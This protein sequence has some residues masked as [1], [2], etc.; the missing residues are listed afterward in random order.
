MAETRTSNIIT[1]DQFEKM[2]QSP[3]MGSTSASSALKY[4]QSRGYTVQGYAGASPKQAVSIN[5]QNVKQQSQGGTDTKWGQTFGDIVQS[6]AP[7]QVGLGFAEKIANITTKPLGKA[8]EAISPEGSFGERFGQNLQTAGSDLLGEAETQREENLRKIGGTTAVVGATLGGGALARGAASK[9][10]GAVIPKLA[11]VAGFAGESVGATAGY[12]ASQGKEIT[13]QDLKT[14]LLIDAAIQGVFKIPAASKL[15]MKAIK[16]LSKSDEAVEAGVKKA[17]RGI[18]KAGLDLPEQNLLKEIPTE[19]KDFTQKA[20]DQA[21]KRSER[22]VEFGEGG[23]AAKTN[24][25]MD[26]VGDDI[27]LIKNKIGSELSKT[28]KIIGSEAKKLKG[29]AFPD[30]RSAFTE[31]K[32]SLDDLNIQLNKKGE[33]TND[34]FKGSDIDGL[35]D[36][37][38]LI[39]ELWGYLKESTESAMTENARDVLSKVRNIGNKLFKGKGEITAAKNPINKVRA[40]LRKSLEELPGAYGEA[41]RKYSDLLEIEDGL[42]RSVG[43]EGEKASQFVRRLFG[44]A[45]GQAKSIVEMIEDAASKYNIKSGENITGKT[46]IAEFLDRASGVTPPQGLQGQMSEAGENILRKGV[47]RGASEAVIDAVAKKLFNTPEKLDAIQAFLDATDNPQAVQE[48]TAV[49]DELLKLVEEGTT[50][51]PL[52]KAIR[53]MIQGSLTE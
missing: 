21:K 15:A 20:L 45:P 25:A 4:L 11:G 42:T 27:T 43:E 13:D 22:I 6:S 44:R 47:Q 5:S 16:G 36:D 9:V 40:A 50:P 31:L 52:L 53:A 29:Q 30:T 41:A 28:G 33:L 34:S 35:T 18:E 7:M 46:A 37:Q 26:L 3:E 24:E 10:A 8:V 51:R 32:N 17:T 39:M 49:M 2:L 19:L 23:T 12:Q 48:A 14:G 1:K 38:D